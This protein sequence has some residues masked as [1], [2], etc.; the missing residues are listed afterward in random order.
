MANTTVGIGQR[1]LGFL[2][3]YM[4]VTLLSGWWF[5]L[6]RHT[7]IEGSWEFDLH[8]QLHSS[9]LICRTLGGNSSRCSIHTVKDGIVEVHHFYNLILLLFWVMDNRLQTPHMYPLNGCMVVEVPQ[10]ENNACMLFTWKVEG[11]AVILYLGNSNMI[12]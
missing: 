1:K 10:I 3:R 6:S 7:F 4:K 5:Y 2:A 9:I 11:L 8:W 12:L